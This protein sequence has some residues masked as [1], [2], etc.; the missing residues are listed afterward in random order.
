MNHGRTMVR[1]DPIDFPQLAILCRGNADLPDFSINSRPNPINPQQGLHCL[2]V[3]A[4]FHVEGMPKSSPSRRTTSKAPPRM[5]AIRAMLAQF[6]GGRQAFSLF[7]HLPDLD[8][9][10]KDAE[11]CFVAGNRGLL[12]RLG[13]STEEELQGLTDAD[14]HPARVAREIREDDERVMRTQEPLIDRVE[15]LYARSQAKNWYVTTKLPVMGAN[16]K[17]IGIM[18]FVR[19]YRRGEKSVPGAER[20]ERVVAHIHAHHAKPLSVDELAK[21]AHLSVRQLHRQFRSVFGMSTQ[22]FIVR[23]RVQAASDDLLLTEKPLSEI[24]F[25]HG[26]CDQSA[27]SRRFAEHTGE[28]PLRFRQRSRRAL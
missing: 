2:S 5:A 1:I 10:V 8:F 24:A 12:K 13:F 6:G 4:A 22:T 28:T 17:V 19:P 14:I 3:A 25:E 27:F 7:D 23:T 18:G 20:L 15:A 11:G 16:G 26:F 21:I 9:F